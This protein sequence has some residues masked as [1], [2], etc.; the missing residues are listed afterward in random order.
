MID[1]FTEAFEGVRRSFEAGRLAHAYVIVGSPQGE[2][3]SMAEA[4][5]RLLFCTDDKKPCGA[6]AGCLSVAA[7]EHPDVLWLEP[8][9]KS[10]VITV[11]VMRGLLRMAAQT[12]FS[13]GWKAAVLLDAD[14]INDDA[15]NMFLKTLE[16]P[17]RR[18]LFLLVSASPQKLL[19][20]IVSRCQR[21]LVSTE[22]EALPRDVQEAVLAILRRSAAGAVLDGLACA[23]AMKAILDA[24]KKRFEDEEDERA[25]REK[26]DD[27]D[28]PAAR[29]RARYIGFR[30]LIV[31]LIEAWHRDVL[32]CAVGADAGL[33]NL[34]GERAALERHAAALGYGGAVQGLR[35]VL[36]LQRQLDRLTPQDYPPFEAFFVARAAA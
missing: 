1:Q 11:E 23:G 18:T 5:L 6:C 7:R 2:G 4:I 22:P 8:E 28:I 26:I 35:G 34:Q 17:S 13:G 32:L 16:E 12:S 36:N 24:A 3:R 33:L 27:D 25:T 9:S 10:R 31:R 15:A 21:L 20:T 14:R 29:A 19:P 30:T